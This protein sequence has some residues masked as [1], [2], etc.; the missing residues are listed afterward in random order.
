MARREAIPFDSSVLLSAHP[1][2]RQVEAPRPRANVALLR[3]ALPRP[4]VATVAVFTEAGAHVRS[5][6]CGELAAGEHACGWNGCDEHD[7]PVAPGGYMVRVLVG[8]RVLTS[9]RV[10]IA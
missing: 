9:R 4:T 7:V 8:E 3:F 5:V 6:L 1:V 2:R 10:I